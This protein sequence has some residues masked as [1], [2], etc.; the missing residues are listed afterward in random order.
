MTEREAGHL[1][2]FRKQICPIAKHGSLFFPCDAPSVLLQYN[3]QV[4]D[5]KP[6]IYLKKQG[7]RIRRSRRLI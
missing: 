3:L 5:K 1:H 4:F 6:V 7:E 2:S